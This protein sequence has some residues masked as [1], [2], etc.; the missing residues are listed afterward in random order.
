LIASPGSE[1]LIG[2]DDTIVVLVADNHI[3][4]LKLQF[5]K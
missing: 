4:K 1:T 2:P 3:E 5:L